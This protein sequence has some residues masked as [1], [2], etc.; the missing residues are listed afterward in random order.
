MLD[1]IYHMISRYLGIASFG[2]KMII[3][4]HLYV[5]LQCRHFIMLP[6]SVNYY[7]KYTKSLNTKK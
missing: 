5:T 6:K 3:F 1:S 2:V 4:G 7:G